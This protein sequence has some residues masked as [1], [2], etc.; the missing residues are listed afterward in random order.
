MISRGFF[1]GGK[2]EIDK[3]FFESIK[4]N[5]EPPAPVEYGAAPG[6]THLASL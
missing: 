3:E 4:Q 5:E 6:A 1:Y 2:D